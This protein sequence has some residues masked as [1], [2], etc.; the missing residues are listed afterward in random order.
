VRKS[1]D[2][3]LDARWGKG[4]TS[5]PSGKFCVIMCNS[6]AFGFHFGQ[7]LF[8]ASKNKLVHSSDVRRLSLHFRL[9]NQVN[10]TLKSI[11]PC[12]SSGPH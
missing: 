7:A 6:T 9:Y 3:H 4:T 1:P 2:E 12:A 10:G 5:R 11:S 8:V